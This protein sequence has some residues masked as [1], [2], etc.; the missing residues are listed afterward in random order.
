MRL[1]LP[2]TAAPEPGGQGVCGTQNSTTRWKPVMHSQIRSCVLLHSLRT[3]CLSLQTEVQCWQLS[4][5]CHCS[6]KRL[7]GQGAQ[8]V[9]SLE[10]QCCSTAVPG[11]HWS[12]SSSSEVMGSRCWYLGDS[13]YAQAKDIIKSYRKGEDND[14]K[15]FGCVFFAQNQK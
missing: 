9:G 8:T 6:A 15:M 14:N 4:P 1:F 13:W 10:V 3:T 12:H 5:Q 11:G 2:S 7:S